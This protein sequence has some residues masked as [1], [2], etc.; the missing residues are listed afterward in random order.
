M[1]IPDTPK[2]YIHVPMWGEAQEVSEE[3]LK[4]LILDSNEDQW[5]GEE[6]SCSLRFQFDPYTHAQNRG[7]LHLIFDQEYG[8]YIS[9][10]F[11]DKASKVAFDPDAPEGFIGIYICGERTE[12]YRPCFFDRNTACLVALHFLRTQEE[13]PSIRWKDD[14]EIP[15]P[16][17]FDT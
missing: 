3:L 5:K 16:E 14:H 13:Y 6:P 7:S 17:D 9:I 4:A 1:S 15:L 10:N 8:F 12:L 11:S 2:L